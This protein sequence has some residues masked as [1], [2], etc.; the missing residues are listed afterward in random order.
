[1]PSTGGPVEFFTLNF[2]LTPTDA[3]YT[4]DFPP[5]NSI[6]VGLTSDD[7]NIKYYWWIVATNVAGQATCTPVVHSFLVLESPPTSVENNKAL[8][9]SIYPNPANQKF[10]IINADEIEYAKILNTLGQTVKIQE[11]NRQDL[12]V[13]ISDLVPGVYQVILQSYQGTEKVIKLVKE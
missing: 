8:K 4:F 3:L 7:A 9:A 11:V 5:F 1:M 2:G 10:N 6:Q 13:D 12:A